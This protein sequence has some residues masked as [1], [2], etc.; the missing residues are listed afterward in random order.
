MK[1]I[2]FIILLIF[3]K[4]VVA[5]ECP[6]IVYG[7]VDSVSECKEGKSIAYFT[8]EELYKGSVV[9]TLKVDFDCS[10]SCLMS[11]EKGDKWLIYATYKRFD[12]LVVS[13]CSHSRKY[14]MDAAQDF[15]TVSA[16]H[17]FEED[18]QFLKET[19][20]IQSF[21][22]MDEQVPDAIKSAAR[23]EQPSGI[24]KLILLAISF[25]VMAI[26]YYVTRKKNGK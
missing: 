16:Q 22:K 11:F 2:C 15:Y 3:S 6:S 8:I 10:S 21:S 19:F 7:A 14:F 12:E 17:T 18:K 13:L 20:G 23:N 24:N 4:V 9:Q 5:C 25:I 1:K 26:V